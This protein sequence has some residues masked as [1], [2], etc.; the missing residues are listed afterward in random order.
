MKTP[1]TPTLL[2]PLLSKA[3]VE[4]LAHAKRSSGLTKQQIVEDALTLYFDPKDMKVRKSKTFVRECLARPVVEQPPP[5]PKGGAFRISKPLFGRLDRA[6]KASSFTQKKIVGDALTLYLN[7]KDAEARKR[8]AFVWKCLAR[9][10][11]EQPPS[12]PPAPRKILRR[13]D[14]IWDGF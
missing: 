9:P 11:V 4:R 6:T 8:Q 3:L 14:N 5:A 7:P 10:M 12:S 2:A 13:S 1:L